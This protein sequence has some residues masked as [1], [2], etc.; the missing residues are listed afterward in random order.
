MRLRWI[1]I[2]L[3]C[4][5]IFAMLITFARCQA[6]APRLMLLDNI[7]CIEYL[8]KFVH[9]IRER[10]LTVINDTTLIKKTSWG[11]QYA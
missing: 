6:D 7:L 2:C 1:V 3:P 10:V 11:K 9:V 8:R 4:F 5:V